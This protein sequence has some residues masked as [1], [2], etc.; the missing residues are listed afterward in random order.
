VEE[1]ERG[2][3]VIDLMDALRRSVRG[4]AVAKRAAPKARK[5]AKKKRRSPRKKAA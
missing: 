2:A 4:K 3:K 5:A 1:P